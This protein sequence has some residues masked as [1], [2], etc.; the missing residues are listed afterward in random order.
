MTHSKARKFCTSIGM[1]LL[2]LDSTA[3]A[4]TKSIDFTRN[5]FRNNRRAV[6]YVDGRQGKRCSIL[7]GNGMK[8]FDWC[9]IGYTFYCEF[10]KETSKSVICGN[11]NDDSG[12]VVCSVDE[13]TLDDPTYNIQWENVENSAFSADQIRE[14][15]F[16]N[17]NFTYLP[18]MISDAFP[19][20]MFLGANFLSIKEISY[21][22]FKGLSKLEQIVMYGNQIK[23]ITKEMFKDLVS[24]K[25]LQLGK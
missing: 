12:S 4:E 17:P 25:N 16:T 19:D 5:F 15:I 24:L 11:T 7:K 6:V 1:S 13:Q 2:D 18:V 9:N 22:N 8:S 10:N 21:E 20:L 3:E 23:I 14:I